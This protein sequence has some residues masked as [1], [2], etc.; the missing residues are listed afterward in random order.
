MLEATENMR[1]ASDAL[2]RFNKSLHSESNILTQEQECQQTFDLDFFRNA[3]HQ[4]VVQAMK[5]VADCHSQGETIAKRVT[6]IKEQLRATNSR[7]GDCESQNVEGQELNKECA[8][9]KNDLRI[10]GHQMES[11][12]EVLT[13]RRQEVGRLMIKA[14]R[15]LKDKDCSKSSRSLADRFLRKARIEMRSL[16]STVHKCSWS[17]V[18]NI[19]TRRSSRRRR[20][21]LRQKQIRDEDEDLSRM[22]K[23]MKL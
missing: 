13:R 1:A 11:C 3:E 21:K 9:R 10:L 15:V 14:R 22:T 23:R 20:R 7:M 18:P 19:N 4:Q 2:S 6:E 12:R 5:K 17:S 16:M 8:R